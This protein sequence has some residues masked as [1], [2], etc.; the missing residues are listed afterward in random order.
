MQQ[1]IPRIWEK[2]FEIVTVFFYYA[3]VMPW[4][5]RNFSKTSLKFANK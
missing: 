3:D 1:G 2:V 5:S 4:Y